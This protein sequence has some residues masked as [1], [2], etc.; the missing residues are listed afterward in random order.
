MVPGKIWQKAMTDDI[1][2]ISKLAQQI[3]MKNQINKFISLNISHAF[4]KWFCVVNSSKTT[5][6]L[7]DI[8]RMSF[9]AGSN[10]FKQVCLCPATSF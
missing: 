6:H 3:L 10:F 4:L 7:L 1:K 2:K 5:D 8:I 9:T